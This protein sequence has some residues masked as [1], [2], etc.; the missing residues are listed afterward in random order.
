MKL[1]KIF[2]RDEQEMSVDVISTYEVR[3]NSRHGEYSGSTRPE[4]RA[5]T[6]KTDAL[7]FQKALQDAFALIKHTSGTQVT[8]ERME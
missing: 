8:L 6:T 4:V 1:L 2:F 3:W 7:A 5:F